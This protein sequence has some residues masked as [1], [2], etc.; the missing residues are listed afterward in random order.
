MATQ[1]HV[2]SAIVIDSASA[3]VEHACFMCI[4]MRVLLSCSNVDGAARCLHAQKHFARKHFAMMIAPNTPP[5]ASCGAPKDMPS[6][7]K[8][9][10]PDADGA[11]APIEVDEGMLAAVR[12]WAVGNVAAPLEDA[13]GM[14]RGFSMG[15]A[16]ADAYVNLSTRRFQ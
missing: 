11:A 15:D 4:I 1:T 3:I 9:D 14:A 13:D 7:E 8:T 16:D 12:A 2:I 5:R 10:A 6:A